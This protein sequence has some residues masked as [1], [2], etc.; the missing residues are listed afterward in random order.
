MLLLY[1]VLACRFASGSQVV[2]TS[3]WKTRQTLILAE[4]T[5]LTVILRGREVPGANHGGCNKSNENKNKNP[6]CYWT[7]IF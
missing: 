1:G 2:K 5:V 3:Y 7:I 4:G 6:C